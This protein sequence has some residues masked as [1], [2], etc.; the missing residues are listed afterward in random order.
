MAVPGKSPLNNIRIDVPCFEYAERPRRLW[1][2]EKEPEITGKGRQALGK[3][4]ACD[5][6]GLTIENVIRIVYLQVQ[7]A[8]VEDRSRATDA[9][10]S[11]IVAPNHETVHAT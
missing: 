3:K 11:G 5:G 10:A 6:A 7:P 1:T 2:I 8:I 4:G 9:R